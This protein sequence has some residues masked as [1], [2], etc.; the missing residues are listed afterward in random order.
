MQLPMVLRFKSP[1]LG[2]RFYFEFNQNTHLQAMEP[3]RQR[4]RRDSVAPHMLPH[5]Q[6]RASLH[7]RIQAIL[8]ESFIEKAETQDRIEVQFMKGRSLTSV[9]KTKLGMNMFS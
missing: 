3:S 8:D 4:E 5:L 9:K 6:R 1:R 2:T 7:P